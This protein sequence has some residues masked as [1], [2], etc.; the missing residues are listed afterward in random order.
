SPSSIL[1]PRTIAAATGVLAQAGAHVGAVDWLAPDRACDIPFEGLHPA[2][3]EKIVRAR[4][5]RLVID[6][7]VQNAAGRRKRILVADMEST[8]VTR[9][10]L[11]ELAATL[12]LSD[13]IAPITARSMQGEIEFAQSL[14]ERV[15]LLAGQPEAA[16]AP[17]AARIELTPGARR[18]VRTMRA[19]GAYT[20]LVS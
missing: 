12:G 2:A 16:L 1:D 5:G 14:R 18:L 17:V 3:A 8:I 6:L 15:A 20:A 9:E 7:A 19:A 11:D 4:L 10:L 13:L